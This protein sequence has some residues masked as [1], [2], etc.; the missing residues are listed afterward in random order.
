VKIPAADARTYAYT[1]NGAPDSRTPSLVLNSF[2]TQVTTT[3]SLPLFLNR[4]H[5]LRVCKSK[6]MYRRI[7]AFHPR[8]LLVL[9]DAGA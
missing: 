3:S 5:N 4:L 1:E 6:Q 2:S 9:H 7:P 8:T